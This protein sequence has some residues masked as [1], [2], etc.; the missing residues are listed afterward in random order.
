MTI[1]DCGGVEL[2]HDI[3]D[4]EDEYCNDDEED[5]NGGFEFP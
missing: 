5:S 1:H 2:V 3:I 4:S